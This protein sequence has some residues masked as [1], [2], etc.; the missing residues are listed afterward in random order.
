MTLVKVAFFPILTLAAG[1]LW[2]SCSLFQETGQ[3][4]RQESWESLRGRLVSAGAGET[5]EVGE[6]T[7]VLDP[8]VILVRPVHIRGAGPGKSIFLS[9]ATGWDEAAL[10]FIMES[11]DAGPRLS[12]VSFQATGGGE[13]HSNFLF[14]GGE[15]AGFRV[16]HCEFRGGGAHSLMMDGD[17]WG[18]V[19]HCL[20]EDDSQES[21]SVRNTRSQ[22]RIWAES[23]GGPAD[24]QEAVFIE[25]CRFHFRSKGTHA[26][27]AVNGS[28][29]VFRKN[30]VESWLTGALVDGHGNFENDRSQYS[31]EVYSNLLVNRGSGYIGYGVYIRG[32]TA[33]IAGN[34]LEGN[35]SAPICLTNYRSW[36]SDAR[37][38]P[39]ETYTDPVDGKTYSPNVITWEDARN[40]S[41]SIRETWVWGNT[42]RGR[43][44]LP[45]GGT[46]AV[47]GEVGVTVLP[48]GHD[49]D[50]IR[51]ER[52]YFEVDPGLLVASYPH[53]LVK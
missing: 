10:S 18:V 25:D 6:G 34:R 27:T 36:K 9:G 38:P 33:L 5:V 40:L 4:N 51:A 7:W 20:F 35:F 13:N 8:P 16:D 32:G 44:G 24:F 37:Y 46:K 14:L 50:H 49:D 48:R 42:L 19:D 30:E 11:S 47:D 17:L 21:L 12:G 15:M 31:L 45:S 41:D 52:D 22:D 26:V 43:T 29:V 2:A 39:A 3:E 53:P 28:R 23:P 1:L